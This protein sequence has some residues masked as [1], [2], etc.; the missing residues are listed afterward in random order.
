MLAC[1]VWVG[2]GSRQPYMMNWTTHTMAYRC[3]RTLGGRKTSWDVT[4]LALSKCSSKPNISKCA[5]VFEYN[6][7]SFAYMQL[8][9][10]IHA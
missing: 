10:T 5:C 3:E 1:L 7:E 9:L 4:G 8:K 2:K 6:I